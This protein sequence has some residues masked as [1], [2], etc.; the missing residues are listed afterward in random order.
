VLL[1]PRQPV[2]GMNPPFRI[3][4]WCEV[5]HVTRE[6]RVGFDLVKLDFNLPLCGFHLGGAIG[7]RLGGLAHVHD[8]FADE[9][10]LAGFNPQIPVELF[11]FAVQLVA[12]RPCHISVP[13]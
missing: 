13:A 4:R 2:G 9:R 10:L 11:L 12:F 8:H 6:N 1:L 7:H 5:E 3:C